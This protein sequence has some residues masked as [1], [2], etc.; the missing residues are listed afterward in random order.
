MSSS[1]RKWTRNPSKRSYGPV[2]PSVLR[3]EVLKSPSWTFTKNLEKLGGID[4]LAS[5]F[6]V[7]WKCWIRITGEAQLEDW[8]KEPYSTMKE[9]IDICPLCGYD[10]WRGRVWFPKRYLMA[11]EIGNPSRRDRKL[12]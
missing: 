5:N 4:K 1:K 7:C 12:T 9:H 6:G 2:N 10:H 8:R 3:N 11:I